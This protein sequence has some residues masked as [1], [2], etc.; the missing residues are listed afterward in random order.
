MRNSK[1]SIKSATLRISLTVCFLTCGLLAFDQ[2]KNSTSTQM[3]VYTLVVVSLV[4]LVLA[5]MYLYSALDYDP[6][7]PPERDI[8]RAAAMALLPFIEGLKRGSW[9]PRSWISAFRFTL[10]PI[11][12]DRFGHHSFRGQ[13]DQP[14]GRSAIR[15]VIINDEHACLLEL[16]D[17]GPILLN[18]LTS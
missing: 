1:F 6:E 9:R 11:L 12:D 15:I 3:G 16:R 14:Q 7:A 13:C 2:S 18:S 4:G 5:L 17:H 8:I 10:G